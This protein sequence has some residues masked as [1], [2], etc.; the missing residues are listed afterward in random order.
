MLQLSLVPNFDGRIFARNVTKDTDVEV[1]RL[2]PFELKVFLPRGY[3]SAKAPVVK[4]L[5]QFYTPYQSLVSSMLRERW[6]E[7]SPVLYDYVQFI[8]DDLV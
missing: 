1:M 4:I 3:P 5:S 6:S 7:G 2:P 8:Q